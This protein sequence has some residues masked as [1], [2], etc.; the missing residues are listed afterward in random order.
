MNYLQDKV[1]MVTGAGSGFG[2]VTA[3]QLARL[4]ARVTCLDVVSQNAEETAGLITDAGG[5]ALA[6]AADVTDIDSLR[7][8]VE[9]TIA[10]WGQVDALINNAGT[11]PLAFMADHAMAM[12]S[13]AR[14]IDIN[15]K[16]VVNGTAAVFDQMIAQGSGHIV[17]ISSIYAN[18]PLAGAAVYGATKASVAYFSDAVRQECRGKIKVSVIKPT[19]STSTNLTQTVLNPA[20]ALGIAGQNGADFLQFLQHRALGTIPD[21]AVDPDGMAYCSIDPEYIAAAIVHVL[22]QPAGVLISDMTVRA[23]N[24]PFIV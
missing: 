5:T 4:G 10:T 23:T 7:A 8:A 13:W 3:L 6:V 19:G 2:R 17:N 9:A 14:C 21:G 18:H 24:D 11:M 15:F 20:A 1:V 12:A 16:G 22:N